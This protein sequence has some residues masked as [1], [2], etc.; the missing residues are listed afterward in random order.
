MGPDAP[1]RASR[2][3]NP[4][5]PKPPHSAAAQSPREPTANPL[6]ATDPGHPVYNAVPGRYANRIGNAEFTLDGETYELD[7]NDGE[8]TLHSGINNWSYRDWNVTDVTDE[9]ITFSIYD[10]EGASTGFPGD[11]Y[12][13]VTYSV[14]GNT[15]HISMEATAPTKRTREWTFSTAI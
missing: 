4:S 11:V 1:S 14:S 2:C 5:R 12:S 15:W 3:H 10:P 6:P 9:S 13:N 7:K 8:N